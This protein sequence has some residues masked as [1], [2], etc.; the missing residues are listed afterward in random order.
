MTCHT[1]VVQTRAATGRKGPCLEELCSVPVEAKTG[2]A[3]TPSFSPVVHK[4]SQP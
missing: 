4:A 1:L 3:T 2:Q